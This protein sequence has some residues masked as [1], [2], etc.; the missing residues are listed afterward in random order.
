MKGRV[1]RWREKNE[2]TLAMTITTEFLPLF[3]AECEHGTVS[4]SWKCNGADKFNAYK[5]ELK[6]GEY[7][8]VETCKTKA[9]ETDDV[10]SFYKIASVKNDIEVDFTKPFSYLLSYFGDNTKVFTPEDD[11]KEIQS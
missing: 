6:D 8:F 10:K 9:Y 7:A 5:S 2:K 3:S 11:Q 4:Y 1:E